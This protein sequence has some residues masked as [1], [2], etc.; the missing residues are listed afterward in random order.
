M[1]G[2]AFIAI[3]LGADE[4]IPVLGFDRTCGSYLPIAAFFGLFRCHFNLD[5][6]YGIVIHTD[7]SSML[8]SKISGLCKIPRCSIAQEIVIIFNDEA[9]IK[10]GLFDSPGGCIIVNA[11]ETIAAAVEIDVDRHAVVGGLLFRTLAEKLHV[12]IVPSGCFHGICAGILTL[13]VHSVEGDAAR[14]ILVGGNLKLIAYGGPFRKG[15]GLLKLH[16]GN[17]GSGRVVALKVQNG[18]RGKDTR[19]C[20]GHILHCHYRLLG[21]LLGK[22][23]L[24]LLL[25]RGSHQPEN[26]Q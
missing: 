10:T 7:I 15:V 17:H 19:L 13:A 11:V 16:D 6:E 18:I 23:R 8:E 5:L 1:T 3:R 21:I 24:Y 4:H 22:R 2:K 9:L 25:A 14:E 26:S 20:R 12:G